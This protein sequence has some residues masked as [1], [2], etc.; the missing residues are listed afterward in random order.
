MRVVRLPAIPLL[1]GLPGGQPSAVG[2]WG[3]GQGCIRGKEGRTQRPPQRRLDR[4]LEETVQAVRGGY[5]Q[6]QMLW[7][8]AL[9]NRKTVPGHRLGAPEGEAYL[10][11]SQCIPGGVPQP[12]SPRPRYT[13]QGRG[14]GRAPRP[15]SSPKHSTLNKRLPGSNCKPSGPSGLLCPVAP[16]L[17]ASSG[18]IGSGRVS[19]WG[20]GCRWA[21]CFGMATRARTFHEP[22]NGPKFC[23]IYTTLQEYLWGLGAS[24]TLG[25]QRLGVPV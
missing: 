3:G 10:L 25:Y 12:P 23:S 5:C 20:G 15:G 21:S 18:R 13:A 22:A 8:L 24:T 2:G 6:L 16:R 1:F 14:L 7:R 17:A 9:A 4:R 11:P 19:D